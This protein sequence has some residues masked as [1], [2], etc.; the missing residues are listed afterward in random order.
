MKKEDK[1]SGET[2]FLHVVPGDPVTVWDMVNKY[3][4]YEI[5]PTA[6]TDNPYPT[7]AAGNP[8]SPDE[9]MPSARSQQKPR[10]KNKHGG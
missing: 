7:I 1:P 8:Y 5:Q 6:D 9:E 2:P 3:G 4:T 10:G